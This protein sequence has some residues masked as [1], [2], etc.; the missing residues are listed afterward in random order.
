LRDY[1]AP[2]LLHPVSKAVVILLF[3]AAL[4]AH[5]YGVTRVDEEFRL[6]DVVPDDSYL[7]AHNR[8]SLER[9]GVGNL[10]VGVYFRDVDLSAP[11]MQQQALHFIDTARFSAAFEPAPLQSWL[12]VFVTWYRANATHNATLDA[13]GFLVGPAFYEALRVFLGRPQF[14]DFGEDLYW[15]GERTSLLASRAFILHVPL[16]S[17]DASKEA[18]RAS[19]ALAAQHPLNA[20]RTP[21]TYRALLFNEWYVFMEQFL[22][23]FDQ[24]VSNLLVS[25][26][27]VM[28]IATLVLVHPGLVLIVTAVVAMMDAHIL[29]SFWWWGLSVNSVTVIQLVMA[30]GLIVDY[31]L[32][33]S[34]LFLLQPESL[35]RDERVRETFFR[36]GSSVL[37]SGASTLIGVLP[38]AFANSEIFRVFFKCFV[39]IVGTGLSHGM[40]LLPVLLSLIGPALPVRFAVAKH[41]SLVAVDPSQSFIATPSPKNATKAKIA[42]LQ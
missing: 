32:H 11:G 24:L 18:L 28:L 12:H 41:A 7:R 10:R 27:V 39:S 34:H 30:V 29:G 33:I 1:Y 9:F 26:T 17:S 35:S 4:G 3:G 6:I 2:V 25:L 5:L 21:A 13:S 40:I 22:V 42:G 31:N 8:L 20:A 15:N 16:P 14:Y 36:I 23:I 19:K 38:L 37:L